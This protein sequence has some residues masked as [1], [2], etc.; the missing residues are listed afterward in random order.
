[1]KKELV[2]EFVSK[3]EANMESIK[4]VIKDNLGVDVNLRVVSSGR[5]EINVNL[6]EFECEESKKVL[7]SHPL[8][9]QM[10]KDSEIVVRC[11]YKEDLNI[12]SFLIQIFYEHNYG[13]GS[14]GTELMAFE[15]SLE[16]GEV[17]KIRK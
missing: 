9:Q 2:N 8:L 15:M 11:W 17:K 6:E 14:N 16:D 5:N 1:M 12:A 10:F 7:T 4:K 3:L 13:G